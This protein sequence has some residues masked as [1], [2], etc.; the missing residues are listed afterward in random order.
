[1][2][3]ATADAQMPDES[4]NALCIM[5]FP[6]CGRSIIGIEETNAA[7]IVLLRILEREA[8]AAQTISTQAVTASAAAGSPPAAISVPQRPSRETDAGQSSEPYPQSSFELASVDAAPTIPA[9]PASPDPQIA[10]PSLTED[11]DTA[12]EPLLITNAAALERSLIRS[13]LP[14]WVT[15]TTPPFARSSTASAPRCPS[16]RSLSTSTSRRSSMTRRRPQRRRPLGLQP[17]RPLSQ[18]KAT[19]R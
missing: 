11:Q 19:R 7:I 17:Q 14:V 9:S 13:T 16:T 5:T 6:T 3:R 2:Q 15:A 4:T 12:A 18:T 8:Q 10:A 1:M